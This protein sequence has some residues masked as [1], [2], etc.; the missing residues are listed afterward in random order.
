M[1]G[2]GFSFS[3]I[4]KKKKKKNSFDVLKK[5]PWHKASIDC[6]LQLLEKWLH[7]REKQSGVYSNS[8]SVLVGFQTNKLKDI[9]LPCVCRKTY[10][11]Y[12][13]YKSHMSQNMSQLAPKWLETPC[14]FEGK[15][16][17]RKWGLSLCLKPLNIKVEIMK[18][19]KNSILFI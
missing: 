18:R 17:R 8:V 4:I 16:C 13:N 6:S 9:I 5:V 7:K 15:F 11:D 14:L 12:V 3:K 1:F 10:V 2:F 19:K